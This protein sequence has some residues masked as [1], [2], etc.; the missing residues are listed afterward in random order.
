MASQSY[1][2]NVFP[3]LGEQRIQSKTP[4][5]LRFLYFLAKLR[6]VQRGFILILSAFIGRA[7][8]MMLEPQNSV[9]T[10]F[11]PSII[12]N[13]NQTSPTNITLSNKLYSD[14]EF[15]TIIS[16]SIDKTNKLR[17][18]LPFSKKENFIK[19]IETKIENIDSLSSKITPS[20]NPY[21]RIFYT[22]DNPLPKPFA[23]H[24]WTNLFSLYNISLVSRFIS[25]LPP[26]SL[27]IPITPERAKQVRNVADSDYH[28]L[29]KFIPL[30]FTN[31]EYVVSDDDYDKFEQLQHI[32]WFWENVHLI[33]GLWTP[34]FI[35][36]VYL[37]I[38]LYRCIC[39]RNYAEW[40][41]S[42]FSNNPLS[43]LRTFIIQSTMTS[44]QNGEEKLVRMDILMLNHD[45]EKQEKHPY[46]NSDID[47]ISTN[48]NTS[49][50]AASSLSGDI[51]VYDALTCESLAIIKRSRAKSDFSFYKRANIPGFSM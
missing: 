5:R 46:L 2:R 18:D 37:L 6:L 28:T 12:D 43:R 19:L 24:H 42:L 9:G 13:L 35:L 25:I 40:R 50:V 34:S 23:N 7:I 21:Y 47:L 31:G 22:K 48:I 33:I 14:Q 1:R 8:Y 27:S 30:K 26:I 41:A 32:H 20:L 4:K 45:R 51:R 16:P 15:T 17:N 3:S 11:E 39:S 10:Q 44:G 49:L 29:K 36:F 38:Q